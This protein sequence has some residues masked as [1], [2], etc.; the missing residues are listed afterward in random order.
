MC[1]LGEVAGEEDGVGVDVTVDDEDGG[2]G[3]LGGLEEGDGDAV[4]I[5]GEACL[6]AFGGEL[7]GE[8]GPHLLGDV[9]DLAGGEDGH[10]VDVVEHG[11]EPGE[12]TLLFGEP[13]EMVLGDDGGADIAVLGVFLEDFVLCLHG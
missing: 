5:R 12:V 11:G 1:S 7:L 9:G 3:V 8:F 4:H 13:V 6:V 10:L 2:V